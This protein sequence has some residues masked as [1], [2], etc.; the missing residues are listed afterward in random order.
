MSCLAIYYGCNDAKNTKAK[1]LYRFSG[2]KL[3]AVTTLPPLQESRPEILRL[4]KEVGI[5]LTKTRLSPPSCFLLGMVRPLNFEELGSLVT[6]LSFGF[7]Q[8]TDRMLAISEIFLEIQLLMIDPMDRI[9]KTPA[10]LGDMKHIMYIWEDD[11]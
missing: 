11:R 2:F 1:I 10:K 9:L 8:D 3:W 6:G 5:L 7:I 4:R